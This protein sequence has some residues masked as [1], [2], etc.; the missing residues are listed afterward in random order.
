ML[1]Q[2]GWG[3][4]TNNKQQLTQTSIGKNSA[5]LSRIHYIFLGCFPAH[6]EEDCTFYVHIRER[7]RENESTQ[8]S[9]AFP[10]FRLKSKSVWWPCQSCVAWPSLTT[11]Y[12]Y[13]PPYSTYRS[14]FA[15]IQ[16]HL[17]HSHVTC[18]F[19]VLP[20]WNDI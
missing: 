7:E 8:I 1:Y 3:R 20:A 4:C 9:S 5:T 6:V 19:A 11:E 14:G 2:N 15:V 18:V 10:S 12:P 17:T 13:L 16:T